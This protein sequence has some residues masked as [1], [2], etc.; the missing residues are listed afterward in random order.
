MNCH[1]FREK[2]MEQTDEEALSLLAE[3]DE[4]LSWIEANS[5]SD[6]EEQFMKEYPH[7]SVQLEDRIMQAIYQQQASPDFPPLSAAGQP[8]GESSLAKKVRRR[9]PAAAWIS[10]AGILLAVGLISFKGMSGSFDSAS[11]VEKQMATNMQTKDSPGESDANPSGT[12]PGN[13]ST[14]IAAALK[15]PAAA[16]V[17]SSQPAEVEPS[18]AQQTVSAPAAVSDSAP[19]ADEGTKEIQT[20]TPANP[21][22]EIAIANTAPVLDQS[23]VSEPLQQ[24]AAAQAQT[25]TAA[26]LQAPA[27]PSIPA[28]NKPA[29]AKAP[30]SEQAEASANA[31]AATQQSTFAALSAPQ[32]ESG[33]QMSIAALPATEAEDEAEDAAQ[34][35]AK[36]A[37]G[38]NAASEAAL[39]GPPALKELPEQPLTVSTFT[40]V[41]AAAQVSDLPVPSANALPEGFTLHSVALQYE[42]ETSK[43]VTEIVAE[44]SRNQDLV[45][46]EVTRNLQGKRSLS[47]PGTFSETRLFTVDT[48][49][50]IG[51]TYTDPA[52]QEAQMQH[53]VYFNTLKLNQSLYVVIKGRG[54]ALNDV[55]EL[56]G[57]L[58]WN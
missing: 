43:N 17:P 18:A 28:R 12:N 26:S 11:N 4:C 35:G 24:Q 19:Q 42:S 56:A 13:T 31:A 49:Q 21:S 33:A 22:R 27:H 14:E 1:E 16:P 36:Q 6:E 53:A 32:P 44:Y 58:Q 52:G 48:E 47:I 57:H 34:A 5:I 46:I 7:P 30:V 38:A 54:V 37:D 2:W 51:V 8:L 41:A 23:L 29:A 10:A 9:Y 39:I 50:A 25:E 40:D 3:C 20:E 45:Q 15:K 55:I